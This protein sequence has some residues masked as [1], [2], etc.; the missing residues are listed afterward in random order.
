MIKVLSK[1]LISAIRHLDTFGYC[2]LPERVPREVAKEFGDR[3]LELHADPN[4]STFIRGDEYYQTLFGMLNLDERTWQYAFHED[5]IAIARHFLGRHCRVVEACSK[6]TWPG[7]P[8]QNLHVD[9]AGGF[10]RVPDIPWMINTIWML[11]DFS[12]ANGGT[13][14]VPLSHRSRLKSPPPETEPENP[15]VKAI[16]GPAGSVILWHGGTWHQARAN[17]SNDI[18]I[19]LNIAYYPR[20]F[21]NWIENGHQPVWPE[22]Y[23][24]LPDHYR[25]LVPGRQGRKREEVY[26]A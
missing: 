21:N 15:L 19:G 16:E 12:D 14:V 24:R 22:T 18:R 6:P 23:E 20:W 10:E 3:C 13:G 5:T 8:P 1:E 11:R 25:C 26:E 7:A 2:V 17:R 4:N 9:S